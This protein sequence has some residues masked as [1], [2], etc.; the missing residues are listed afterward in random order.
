MRELPRTGLLVVARTGMLIS[1]VAWIAAQWW[2]TELKAGGAGCAVQMLGFRD[3]IYVSLKQ[4][5]TGWSAKAEPYP[6]APVDFR[7]A[8]FVDYIRLWSMLRVYDTVPGVTMVHYPGRS[9][10]FLVHYWLAATVFTCATVAT[11][12]VLRRRPA[13]R[14]VET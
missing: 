6:D 4:G 5:Q 14:R 1:I 8:S 2:Q 9:L 10:G 12:L 11:H 3:G 13:A 7:I